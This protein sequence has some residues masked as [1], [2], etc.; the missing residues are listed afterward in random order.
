MSI[1]LDYA[2]RAYNSIKHFSPLAIQRNLQE[3]SNVVG[4]LCESVDNFY[5]Q[6]TNVNIIDIK[7]HI[8]QIY[9][10][11]GKL[12]ITLDNT[13]FPVTSGWIIYDIKSPTY[14]N[15]NV[16]GVFYVSAENWLVISNT[17]ITSDAT[18]TITKLPGIETAPPTT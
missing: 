15:N 11:T 14:T 7:S 13:A 3:L 18:I 9:I 8:K 16:Y 2:K 6:Y 4:D 17:N 1:F 10:E 12:T 5:N